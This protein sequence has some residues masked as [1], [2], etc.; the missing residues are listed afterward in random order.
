ML[1]ITNHPIKKIITNNLR[2]S[3]G[4]T[5][6]FSSSLTGL[7]WVQKRIKVRLR[8]DHPKYGPAGKLI[9]VKPGFM[10]QQLYPF[11]LALYCA[12]D[13]IPIHHYQPQSAQLPKTP[14]PPGL[15][16]P[17]DELM[18]GLGIKESFSDEEIRATQLQIDSWK[19]I[20]NPIVKDAKNNEDEKGEKRSRVNI[21][22]PPKGLLNY[23]QEISIRPGKENSP[24]TT[25]KGSGPENS[26]NLYASIKPNELLENIISKFTFSSLTLTS[27]IDLSNHLKIS[28]IEHVSAEKLGEESKLDER[29]SNERL[30]N[31]VKPIKSVGDYMVY[32][33]IMNNQ[34]ELDRVN[35]RY[36]SEN[37][38]QLFKFL[39]K[40]EK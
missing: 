2:N 9:R 8:K 39:V 1:P 4:S 34:V 16:R 15:S 28:R 22:T 27:T 5:R 35:E 11:G 38:D 23:L 36:E 37:N 7:V 24:I 20:Y 30:I 18:K 32:L 29:S 31:Q 12:Q 6:N 33:S 10:R 25:I 17:I 3:L 13:G 40:I 14:P 19:Q 26:Q 21:L